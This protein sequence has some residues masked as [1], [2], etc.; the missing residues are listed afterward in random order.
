[1]LKAEEDLN[2]GSG[3]LMSDPRSGIAFQTLSAFQSLGR[4]ISYV[5][6]S[7]DLNDESLKG[8][9]ASNV[10]QDFWALEKKL[11]FST[12]F[13]F[14]EVQVLSLNKILSPHEQDRILR[15]LEQSKNSLKDPVHGI[16]VLPTRTPDAFL[17]TL[18]SNNSELTIFL[19]PSLFGFTDEGLMEK[20]L[21]EWR[22][23]P[24]LMKAPLTAHAQ[25]LKTDLAYM[26]D[27]A[28]FLVSAAGRHEIR[29]KLLEIPPNFTSPQE[30]FES[31]RTLFLREKVLSAEKSPMKVGNIF[32]AL[33]SRFLSKNNLQSLNDLK[34][35]P[36][37][38]SIPR[39]DNALNFFPTALSKPQRIFSDCAQL[40]KKN[41]HGKSHF[42]QRRVL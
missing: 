3:I 25:E 30:F 37:E 38:K 27:V 4:R 6:V 35:T 34:D 17:E 7:P 29:G 28:A 42:P 26:G 12:F 33:W 24:W 9:A 20:T 8:I 13:I 18:R 10:S 16:V 32:N 41:P 2:E 39:G 23:K 14:P 31:F 5:Q 36:Q 15:L 1:M 21:R 22:L 19:V 11:S 40:L